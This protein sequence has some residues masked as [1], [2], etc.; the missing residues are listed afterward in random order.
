MCGGVHPADVHQVE[1]SFQTGWWTDV[2]RPE[3]LATYAADGNT[4]VLAG[5]AGW[6]TT[7]S[8]R[9]TIKSYLDE[10]QKNNVKVIVSLVRDR[11]TPYG[12]PAQ[13]FTDTITACKS[14]PALYAWYIG[15]EPELYD[16][17]DGNRADDWTIPHGYLATSPGYYGLAKA[18]DPDH[19]MLISFNELYDPLDTYY[20]KVA[21]F[22]DVTD[23]IG[24]HNYPF[25][26]T[27]A[28]FAGSDSRTQYDKWTYM[29]DKTALN[30]KAGFIA[31]CQG[32]GVNSH[33]AIYRDPT[34]A[35]LRH[36][37]FSAVV[38]GVDKVLFWYDGW[39]STS[40]KDLVKQMIGQ[41]QSIGAAMNSG[42]TND[43]RIGVSVTNREQLVYRY[44]VSGSDQVILAVNIANRTVTGGAALNNIRFTL[45]SGTTATQ[46]TVLY[47]S[48]TL[49]VTD[50]TFTDNFAPFAV[51]IYQFSGTS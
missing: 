43:L 27:D 34:L 1:S 3:Y 17:G 45:P 47:E 41:V 51:H 30:N 28:E 16:N 18:A 37:V 7:P 11:H 20:A 31:T 4:L 49:T 19:P 2:T 32:F 48:R 35:E 42:V 10:A 14:H 39:A 5:G 22:L 12:I 33:A 23:L 46:V 6:F 13:D 40:M 44:G 9:D 8:E 26:R 21:H 50:G 36:Q 25:W 38:L 29:L 24:M 15:D